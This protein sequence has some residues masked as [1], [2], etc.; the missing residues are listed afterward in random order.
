[1][2]SGKYTIEKKIG[3][4]G[5]GI[6]YRAIQSGLNRT[7]CI[8]EYFPAGR[9]TRITAHNSVMPQGIDEA[10]FEKYRQAF[11]KEAETLASLQHPSIVEV[12]DIFDENNTSYMV[13]PFIEGRT[14]QQIVEQQGPIDYP[15]AVNYLAQ[16]AD[17]VGYIHQRNILHRDIKPDN[18]I[19]TAEYRAILID[20]GSAR[21]FINDK[22]QAQTSIVTH[23]YAPTEQYSNN[24]RKGAYTDIYALGATFY[25]ILTGKVPLDAVARMTDEMIEP[26]KLNPSIPEEANRTILKAMQMKAGDRHQSAQDFMDDLRNVH[27]SQ[28]TVSQA[29]AY[30]T[31]IQQPATTDKKKSKK[32]LY[33]GVIGGVVLI[34]ILLITIWNHSNKDYDWDDDYPWDTA[35][36]VVDTP[37]VN[38]AVI[39]ST[40]CEPTEEQLAAYRKQYSDYLDKNYSNFKFVGWQFIYLDDDN[41]PEIYVSTDNKWNG[42]LLL[43]FYN[44]KICHATLSL[45]FEYIPHGNRVKSGYTEKALTTFVI[46]ELTDGKMQKIAEFTEGTDNDNPNVKVWRI[47]NK[48][49]SKEEYD[50][51]LHTVFN[52][53]GQSEKAGTISN[54]LLS[55]NALYN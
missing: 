24:S 44:G 30:T 29:A 37:I 53:Y 17:A 27:P 50:N 22:T 8:K 12:I 36:A 40:D 2:Q 46:E 11:K 9:S 39:E 33:I 10:L 21:E 49:V 34:L 52:S 51:S 3:E 31:P 35:E 6:T 18:I 47:D 32:G 38:E 55:M 43:Y 48:N 23:G 41:I 20:F 25:Y 45:G 28:P 14:L 16:V 15:Q 4:G 1:M 19:V 5:F 54:K 42:T 13:M 7:V 26:K